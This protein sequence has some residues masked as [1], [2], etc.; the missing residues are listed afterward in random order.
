LTAGCHG[1]DSDAGRL[2]TLRVRGAARSRGRGSRPA[3][4]AVIGP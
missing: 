4:R 1:V 2:T 3:G